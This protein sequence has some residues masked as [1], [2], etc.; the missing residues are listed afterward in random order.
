MAQRYD[1]VVIGGGH[2]GLTAAAYLAT[3]GRRVNR[4]AVP[5]RLSMYDSASRANPSSA[6]PAA[7]GGAAGGRPERR[8]RTIGLLS[9]PQ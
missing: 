3:A 9:A 4:S 6:F 2:N 1:A 7:E 8:R 5:Y